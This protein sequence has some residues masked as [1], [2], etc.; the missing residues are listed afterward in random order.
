[1]SR[2]G[3]G[4]PCPRCG[5]RDHRVLETRAPRR[6][7]ECRYCGL[8]FST[9]EQVVTDSLSVGIDAPT[10]RDN[11]P[12]PARCDDALEIRE[13]RRK[14]ACF[15]ANGGY[16][17]EARKR[18]R[19]RARTR[20][21]ALTNPLDLSESTGSRHDT[22]R[23]NRPHERGVTMTI[24]PEKFTEA[25]SDL[26]NALQSAL[27]LAA[28]RATAVRAETAAADQLYATVARAVE[29]ARQLRTVGEAGGRQS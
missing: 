20:R 29:A 10:S 23:L 1:M 22:G 4:L 25:F 18:T 6:R 19:Q 15:L 21:R 12:A 7:R 14:T 17:E 5:G 11:L 9:I 26:T 13:I 24:D 28:E 8:R 2:T 16:S 27:A 3:F